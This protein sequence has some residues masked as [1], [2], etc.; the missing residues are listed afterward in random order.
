MHMPIPHSVH[1][2]GDATFTTSIGS[3]ALWQHV[4]PFQTF[5]GRSGASGQPR[6]F[7]KVILAV[8]FKQHLP[9][10]L[11]LNSTCSHSVAQPIHAYRNRNQLK[12]ALARAAQ[13][14]PASFGLSTCSCL[15]RAD[16]VRVSREMRCL[17]L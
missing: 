15:R 1:V 11:T 12:E 5:S 10:N 9:S 3:K 4:H 8:L 14:Q 13:C 2:C 17:W 7:S 6:S 16:A